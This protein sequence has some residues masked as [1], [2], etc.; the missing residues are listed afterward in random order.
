MKIRQGF[1]S[2]SSSTSF[3]IYGIE[4]S[5]SD[6]AKL[7]KQ[8]TESKKDGCEHKFKRTTVKFCPECGKPAY[9]IIK[10]EFDVETALFTWCEKNGLY[11]VDWR[12]GESIAEGNFIGI[13][14]NDEDFNKKNDKLEILKEVEQKLN[15]LFPNRNV[16][17]MSDSGFDG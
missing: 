6:M 3:C 7:V 8:P 10:P 5:E 12:G 2:N 11:L 13:N 1:V 17:F 9:I 14:L 15:K 16:T 4:I